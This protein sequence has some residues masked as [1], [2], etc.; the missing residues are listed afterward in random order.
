MKTKI[1]LKT[2]EQ[3]TTQEVFDQVAEHMLTQDELSMLNG[4]CVYRG[5]NGLKCAA[6]CLIGDDEYNNELME[7]F[8]WADMLDRLDVG[9]STKHN[10]LISKLQNIHDGIEC[11][12][13]SARLL[14][15]A[16][17][18]ELSDKVIT[19]HERKIRCS[20]K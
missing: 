16:T 2:L 19:E 8:T 20:S 13:W 5:D 1:T 14:A 7:G 10:E 9:V 11:D 3:A 18:F 15:V 6:G 12:L 4:T 17:A